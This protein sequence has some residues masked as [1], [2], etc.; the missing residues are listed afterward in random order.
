M[1]QL[2]ATV[3]NI[4]ISFAMGPAHAATM[5]RLA[6][7]IVAAC[8]VETAPDVAVDV[9]PVAPVETHEAEANLTGLPCDVKAVLQTNCAGCHTG[10]TYAVEWATRADLLQPMDDAT[11][12]MTTLGV[13]AV[14]RMN[15]DTRPM[16]PM[17]VAQRPSATDRA[18]VAAWVNA[19][20]PGGA[21]GAVTRP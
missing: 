7:L 10:E 15:S 5:R 20:M 4:S 2:Y 3:K 1:A 14:Q 9:A 18:T 12:G 16:P 13:I 11:G 6:L 17:G 21:C 19:G 8:G